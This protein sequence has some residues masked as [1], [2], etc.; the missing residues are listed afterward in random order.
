MRLAFVSFV[1]TVALTASAC[2][3]PQRMLL[4]ADLARNADVYEVSGRNGL[5]LLDPPIEF[6]PYST[7]DID[8][9]IT[10]GSGS[11]SGGLFSKS[12]MMEYH[13]VSTFALRGW[14]GRCDAHALT[15]TES[16]VTGVGIAA[17]RGLHATKEVNVETTSGYDCDLTGPQGQRWRLELG[18]G[19]FGSVVDAS[20][21]EVYGIEDT[22]GGYV[23]SEPDGDL[24]GAVGSLVV[25]AKGRSE[26]ERTAVAAVSVAVLLRSH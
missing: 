24:V 26:A 25:L 8:R 6:G 11:G 3:P 14:R 17:K 21:G 7:D 9:G 16:E 10:V 19:R 5:L 13:T 15:T 23:I 4:P 2:K 20:R 18:D 1:S 22:A 12:E